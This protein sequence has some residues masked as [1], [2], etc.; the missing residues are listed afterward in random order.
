MTR[1][2]GNRQKSAKRKPRGRGRPFLPGNNANPLG[3]PKKDFDLVTRCRELT[4]D[5]IEHY[6][7]LGRTAR[8]GYA[9]RAGEIV[10]HYGNDKPRSRAEVTGKDGGPLASVD[11]VI[12]V[13]PNDD[14]GEPGA[15]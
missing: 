5:I 10:L 15:D 13:V 9:V 12:L 7:T 2:T 11:Q 1:P 4:A 3:R 6:A 14:S 8:S